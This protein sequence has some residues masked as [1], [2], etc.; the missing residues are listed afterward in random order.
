MS[1]PITSTDPTRTHPIDGLVQGRAYQIKFLDHCE[2]G[3]ALFCK[4]HG[5]FVSSDRVSLFV[6]S[7]EPAV[8][9]G[10]EVGIIPHPDDG[11]IN[12]L[13]NYKRWSILKDAIVSI[14]EVTLGEEVYRKRFA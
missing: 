1:H 2:D 6:D 12:T 8:P 4:L 10:E 11:H 9:E 7:W 14:N 5:S 3:H 13:Q